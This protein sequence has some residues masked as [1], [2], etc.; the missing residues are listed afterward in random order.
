MKCGFRI[1]ALSFDTNKNKK[2]RLEVFSI[3]NIQPRDVC[4]Q[5]FVNSFR[6]ILLSKVL[7]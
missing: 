2:I 3:I 7:L 4:L 6:K 1:I 5:K